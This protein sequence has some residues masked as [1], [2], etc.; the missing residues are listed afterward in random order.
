MKHIIGLTG[1]TG[2]GKSSFSLL[3]KTKGIYVIDC[4]ELSRQVTKNG[5]E[6]LLKLSQAFGEDILKDGYL[7]RKLL[8]SR[9]FCDQNKKQL[10]EDIIFPFI[11][12]LVLKEIEDCQSKTILLDAPTLFESSL[13]ELCGS[14]VAVL[15]DREIRK[16]R[17]IERDGL[18]LEQ[19][20]LRLNAGQNDSFY[21][22]RADHIIYN[23]CS[24]SEFLSKCEEILNIL[25]EE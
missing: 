22:E 6:C 3:A 13:N 4:D 1:P 9:A 25:M 7:D 19:A 21:L 18:T 17:I 2:S 16:D 15:S 5:N 14:V 10:L 8:A 12:S 24:K 11:L 20:E 23:N